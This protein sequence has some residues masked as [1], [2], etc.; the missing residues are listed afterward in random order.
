MRSRGE[1]IE[2][3]GRDSR[4]SYEKNREPNEK[5]TINNQNL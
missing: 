2:R 4:K 1:T 5:L 3:V